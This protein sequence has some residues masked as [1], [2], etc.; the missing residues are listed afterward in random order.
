MATAT[1]TERHLYAVID[2]LA[3]VTAPPVPPVADPLREAAIAAAFSLDA[4]VASGD[5][6]ERTL[7]RAH[8]SFSRTSTAFYHDEGFIAGAIYGYLAAHTDQ[9]GEDL[10]DATLAAIIAIDAWKAGDPA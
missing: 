8:A 1:K 3:T 7:E 2:T 10:A 6:L 4:A 5:S 9:A